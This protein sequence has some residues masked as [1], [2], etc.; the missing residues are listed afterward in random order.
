MQLSD[1]IGETLNVQFRPNPVSSPW[2]AAPPAPG[3]SGKLAGAYTKH[4]H[5]TEF[6]DRVVPA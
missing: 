4:D 1:D 2:S 6:Y 5:I 3:P